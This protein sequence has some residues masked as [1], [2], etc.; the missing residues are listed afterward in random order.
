MYRSILSVRTFDFTRI[1]VR[2]VREQSNAESSESEPR[3]GFAK[4]EFVFHMLPTPLLK[5]GSLSSLYLRTYCSRRTI[6]SL[7]TVFNWVWIYTILSKLGTMAETESKEA[8]G[9]KSVE[10]PVDSGDS[11]PRKRPS[12]G[13]TKHRSSFMHRMSQSFRR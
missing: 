7:V 8:T 12:K 11:G 13:L 1:P 4:Q 9:G 5:V 3:P 6:C 2:V 10:V